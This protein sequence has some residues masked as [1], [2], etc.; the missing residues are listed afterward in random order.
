VRQLRAHLDPV[1]PDDDVDLLAVTLAR[2]A[3]SLL[4]T[5]AAPPS[6]RT[7]PQMRRYAELVV[8]PMVLPGWRC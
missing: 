6:L 3:Q 1:P 2:L 5:T 8:V 7:R 4:L